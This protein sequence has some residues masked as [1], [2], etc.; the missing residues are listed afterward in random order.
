MRPIS[1]TILVFLMAL[2]CGSVPAEASANVTG[3]ASIID[4]D[5]L[6]IR[7]ARIRLVSIDAPESGQLCRDHSDRLWR[8]GQ[9]AAL[10][11]SDMIG[12]RSVFCSVTGQDRYGRVLAHC[13]VDGQDLAEWMVQQGWAIRYYDR[14]GRLR[15]EEIEAQR[16]RR[17]I[18]AGTFDTPSDWRKSHVR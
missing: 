2:S 7:G 3:R 8:C 16:M 12:R 5:T 6:E 9:A 18:W 4:G 1:A 11:L 15:D 14:A 10:A 17:G 13:F